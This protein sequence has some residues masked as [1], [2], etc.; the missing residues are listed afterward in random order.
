MLLTTQ[1]SFYIKLTFM[2]TKG[3]IVFTILLEVQCTGTEV[4]FVHYNKTLYLFNDVLESTTSII[5]LSSTWAAPI[6]FYLLV[7]G[8]PLI[9]DFSLH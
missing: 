7:S 6:C 8:Q 3:F 9:S 1:D 4:Q 2:Q 5:P